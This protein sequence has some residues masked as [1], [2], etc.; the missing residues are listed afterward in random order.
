MIPEEYWQLFKQWLWVILLGGILGA[1]GAY[2]VGAVLLKPPEQYNSRVVLGVDRFVA[3][4]ESA[5]NPEQIGT[6][7]SEYVMSIGQFSQTPQFLDRLRGLLPESLA[8]LPQEQLLPMLEITPNQRIFNVTISSTADTASDARALTTAAASILTDY[9]RISE[10]NVETALVGSQDQRRELLTQELGKTY[11]AI[12]EKIRVANEADLRVSLSDFVARGG[13]TDQ[14]RGILSNL[15]RVQADPELAFLLSRATA[16]EGQIA[17]L[18]EMNE[19]LTLS[20]E[21][22]DSPLFEATPVETVEALGEKPIR[23]R[24]L[25]FLGGLGGLLVGWLLA[26]YLE[27]FRL[28]RAARRAQRSASETQPSGSMQPQPGGFMQPQPAAAPAM[29]QAEI[30]E[31]VVAESPAPATASSRRP[32]R[33]RGRSGK[34]STST[35]TAKGAQSPANAVTERSPAESDTRE[36]PETGSAGAIS[37]NGG[38]AS[39]NVANGDEAADGTAAESQANGRAAESD[40]GEPRFA[41]GGARY[42]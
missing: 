42:E 36:V 15:A 16:L 12:E 31:A 27:R 6:M 37:T 38:L 30:Q 10:Q 4:G 1:V 11:A 9:A 29:M 3:Y 22:A 7:Q 19:G 14:F 8:D 17:D 39:A 21:S 33:S 20:V 26:N 23:G 2:V 34:T 24:N 5:S 18:V 35:A 41:F 13:D 32:K 40:V 28:S 25:A